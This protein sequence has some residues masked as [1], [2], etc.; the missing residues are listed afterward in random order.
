MPII[1]RTILALCLGMV[2]LPAGAEPR[3]LMLKEAWCDWCIK[4]EEEIGPVYD[5]TEEGRRAPLIRADIHEP[6][7]EGITLQR[8]ANFTPTFVLL[9]D[10]EHFFF[11]MLGK[12]LE[13]LDDDKPEGR[14]DNA[15]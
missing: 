9:E 7:P 8:R 3:L 4:W 12:L 10:G 14:T 5:R 2:A 11:G 13:K 1:R 15:S 6:L